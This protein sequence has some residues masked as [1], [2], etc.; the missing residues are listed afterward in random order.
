MTRKKEKVEGVTVWRR[1]KPVKFIPF[2]VKWN[3]M[4]ECPD[5]VMGDVEWTGWHVGRFCKK[6]GKCYSFDSFCCV[7]YEEKVPV[8]GKKKGRK[9]EG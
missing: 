9:K 5:F 8:E 6:K 4:N 3:S 2:D 7:A 1:P